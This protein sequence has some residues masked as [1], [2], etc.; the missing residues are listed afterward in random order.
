MNDLYETDTVAWSERQSEL[1]RRVAAG[2]RLNVAPDWPNIAEEIETL[3]KNQGRELASRVAVILE[4]LIKLAAS[5]ASEPRAVW[6][7]T[8]RRERGEIETLLEDAPSLRTRVPAVIQNKI[9][10][11]RANAAAALV[12]SGE[13]PRCDIGS[14]NY[15]AD[16]LL[17]DWMP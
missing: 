1:L 4:H 10:R 11:A 6:R 7:A 16:E 2:E 3:G 17:G 15:S 5:P 12:D 8:I 9:A 13:V 14:I